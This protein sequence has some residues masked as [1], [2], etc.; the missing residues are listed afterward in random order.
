MK[1]PVLVLMTLGC[2][3]MAQPATSVKH[4]TAL[5]R[6]V[7]APDPAYKWEL[8]DTI[9]GKGFKAYILDLTSQSWRSEKEVDR[10]LWKHWL[11]IIRPETVKYST[12]FLFI[13][14]G[15]NK[16]GPPKTPDVMLTQT[17]LDTG[18]VVAELKQVPNEPLTFSD[19]GR[20][21]TEDGII[22]YTWQKFLNGGDENWP[23]R[24]PMTKAAVKAMDTITAFGASPN[25]GNYN[26]R[27]FVVSGGSKRG[28]TAWTTAAVDKRVDAVVPIVI[29][30][31]NIEPNFEHH[32]QVY[33]FFAPSVKDYV[34]RGL[35][36]WDGTK[37]YRALMKIE[38]P[39]QYRDR[40]TMP[41]YIM[42]AAGDQFFVPDSSQYY[43]NDLKG[44]KLLRYIPNTDHSMRGS[45]ANK[46]LTSYLDL[47]LRDAKRP[48]YSWKV[49]PDGDI[50]VTSKEEPLEVKVWTAYNPDARDFRVEK[51]GRI[52]KD[53][54]LQPVKKGEWIA[55]APAIEKGYAAYFV[56]LTYATGGKYPLKVTTQVKVMPDKYPS[57]PYKPAKPMGTPVKK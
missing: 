32:Y 53:T 16:G 48:E 52:Y 34:E 4:E 24:L 27:K 50:H 56:E 43:W 51:V 33:G 39:Y 11:T 13:T 45:D 54:V 6:Y 55:K 2:A 28:W 17:A 20:P 49:M 9:E 7:A 21:L 22:A 35:M 42:N 14:G 3:L 41:K 46:S 23:L 26:I 18:A 36:D 5:D 19:D 1:R 12:G 47:I 40:L 8:V 44:E 31:L 37:E 15:S 25:P 57:P 29:D 30:M 10:T 38:E